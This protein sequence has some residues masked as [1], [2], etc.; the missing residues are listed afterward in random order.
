[1]ISHQ[2]DEKNQENH[3]FL[4]D[5]L[6]KSLKK[7]EKPFFFVGFLMSSIRN[8][9]KK[10]GFSVFLGLGGSSAD[11]GAREDSEQILIRI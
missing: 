3:S 2:N 5:F 8:H 7:P 9:T 6:S 1:M 10:N 4:Y 11:G